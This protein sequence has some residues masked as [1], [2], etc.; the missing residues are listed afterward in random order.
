[1]TLHLSS[2]YCNISQTMIDI[3]MSCYR[4]MASGATADAED[5]VDGL[6][7]YTREDHERAFAS[8]ARRTPS[9][10]SRSTQPH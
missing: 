7:H 6:G 2:T 10:A 9:V 5:C 1:M 8:V 3:V 4:W